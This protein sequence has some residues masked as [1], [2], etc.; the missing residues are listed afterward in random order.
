MRKFGFQTSNKAGK[1]YI[2]RQL[3]M[4]AI[5][6]FNNFEF[7]QLSKNC[8]HLIA[9]LTQL[10]FPALHEFEVTRTEAFVMF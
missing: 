10:T 3:F 7:N 6:S 2:G 9:I 8:G 4:N 1:S 5:Q